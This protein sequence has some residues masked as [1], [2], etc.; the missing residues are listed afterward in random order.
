LSPLLDSND[1]LIPTIVDT[2]YLQDYQI[3]RINEA[4]QVYYAE[5][6]RI[7]LRDRLCIKNWLSDTDF[8]TYNEWTYQ[9]TG[10]TS[11]QYYNKV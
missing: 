11:L 1:V 9:I 10:Y 6:I 7:L 4:L 3:E 2:T 5:D 8:K